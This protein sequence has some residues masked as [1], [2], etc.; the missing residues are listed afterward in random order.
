MYETE[1]FVT[2]L[3]C[4]MEGDRYEADQLHGLSKVGRPLLVRYGLEQLAAGVDRDK[5]ASENRPWILALPRV[6]SGAEGREL[7]HARRGD[8]TPHRN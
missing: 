8:Y 3:E 4:S 1:T 6:P 5:L 7:H 2:H